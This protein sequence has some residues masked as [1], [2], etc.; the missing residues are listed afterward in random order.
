MAD[1]PTTLQLLKC[2]TVRHKNAGPFAGG[3]R[4]PFRQPSYLALSCLLSFLSSDLLPYPGER[5]QPP[6]HP[7]VNPIIPQRTSPVKCPFGFFLRRLDNVIHI[8]TV[9]VFCQ[10]PFAR[11]SIDS[12]NLVNLVFGTSASLCAQARMDTPAVSVEHQPCFLKTLCLAGSS[13]CIELHFML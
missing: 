11:I 4:E 2:T 9:P 7:T 8:T 3:D 10:P 5:D 1:L 13:Y 12:T 6:D